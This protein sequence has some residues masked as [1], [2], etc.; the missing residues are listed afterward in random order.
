MPRYHTHPF[1]EN[2]FAFLMRWNT[3]FQHGGQIR[4]GPVWPQ[5]RNVNGYKRRL[6]VKNKSIHVLLGPLV[7]FIALSA[8]PGRNG[9]IARASGASS[10]PSGRA[11]A[12]AMQNRLQR[13]ITKAGWWK[14]IVRKPNGQLHHTYLIP[15][16]AYFQLFDWD[17]YFMGVALSNRN[18]GKSLAGSVKDF[19]HFTSRYWSYRGYTPRVV[20]GHHTWAL[21]EMCK[22]FLAQMALRASLTLHTVAWLKPYYSR[23]ADTLWYWRHA[24]RSPDGLF[25]WFDGVESGVDDSAAVIGLSADRTEGVDLACYIYREYLAMADLASLLGKPADV[26]RYQQHAA[27][28]KLLIQKRLWDN[29]AGSFYNRNSRT[30]AFI[31]APEW[32]N[33]VPLWAHVATKRQA[34]IL[35]TRYV[36]NPRQFWTPFGIRSLA[37]ESPLYHPVHG[38]WQGPIWIISNYMVMHGLMNYGYTSQAQQLAKDTV[39]TLLRDIKTTGGM[40]ETYNPNTGVGQND[41]FFKSWDMLGAYMIQEAYTGQDSAGIPSVEK[42]KGLMKN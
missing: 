1:Y 16:A 9:D 42:I 7:M 32:T 35:I 17:T 26:R 13:A 34:H 39:A 40:H 28:L 21:P 22:P 25:K 14:Q 27:K 38:Y 11:A 19:L 37:P 4:R 15:G 10:S 23:L 2:V 3:L 33:L 30:G 5:S 41:G 24:R 36:L 29:N 8:M 20:A 31:P 12:Y 18:R 6:S